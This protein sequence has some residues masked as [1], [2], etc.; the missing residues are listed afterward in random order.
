MNKLLVTG[1]DVFP[2]FGQGKKLKYFEFMLTYR[3]T[4]KS[5]K[6]N[7]TNVAL[8]IY[9]KTKQSHRNRVD[10]KGTQ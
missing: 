3:L 5:P 1:N 8:F 4:Y 7:V 10:R 6:T 9:S 2:Q